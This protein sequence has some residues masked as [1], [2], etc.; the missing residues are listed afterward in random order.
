VILDYSQWQRQ[1]KQSVHF[2]RLRFGVAGKAYPY[3]A[4]T[5]WKIQ[6]SPLRINNKLS[7]MVCDD[8]QLPLTL[9]EGAARRSSRS[10]TMLQNA[11]LPDKV[12]V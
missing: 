6:S 10:S 1:T 3:P 9:P 2:C 4:A 8:C 7:F 5:E 12:T 11:S